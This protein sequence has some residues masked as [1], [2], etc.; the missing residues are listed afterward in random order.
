MKKTILFSFVLIVFLHVRAAAFE[1]ISADS[2]HAWIAS[3][4]S[5][6]LLDVREQ[7][8]YDPRHIPGAILMPWSSGVV[9]Q[10]YSSLPAHVPIA[11]ICKAGSRAACAA[12]VSGR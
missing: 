9:D 7:Y 10:Q 12:G 4:D 2:L 5:L 1:N 8:E 3:G 11:V 6:V